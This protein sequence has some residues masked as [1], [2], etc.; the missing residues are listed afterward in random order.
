MKRQELA[1]IYVDGWLQARRQRSHSKAAESGRSAALSTLSGHS[2][3]GKQT[4]TY[5]RNRHAGWVLAR[6]Q[7]GQIRFG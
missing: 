3:I 6:A 7:I 1:Q 5:Q 4:P 2:G